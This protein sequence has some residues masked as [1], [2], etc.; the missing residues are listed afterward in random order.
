[1]N[2]SLSIGV[3]AFFFENEEKTYEGSNNRWYSATPHIIRMTKDGENDTKPTK[4]AYEPPDTNNPCARG[5]FCLV[6]VAKPVADG[7]WKT[8]KPALYTA[9][10]GNKGIPY[11]HC[12]GGRCLAHTQAP[13]T[14][15]DTQEKSTGRNSLVDDRCSSDSGRGNG[16]SVKK[17]RCGRGESLMR[18]WTSNLE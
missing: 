7:Y 15:I 14:T 18:A 4:G 3:D 1:M 12:E 9:L 13:A 5:R 11:R 10:N 16:R 2:V 8:C 17:R 6:S